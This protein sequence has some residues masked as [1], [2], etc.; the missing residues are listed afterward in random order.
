M[1]LRTEGMNSLGD[2]KALLPWKKSEDEI[3]FTVVQND[4]RTIFII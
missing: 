4:I 2:Q 3:D 1:A